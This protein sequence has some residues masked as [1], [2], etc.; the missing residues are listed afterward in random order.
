MSTENLMELVLEQ[1]NGPDASIAIPAKFTLLL[2]PYYNRLSDLN[3]E[4]G[5]EEGMS[6]L[7][8][9]VAGIATALSTLVANTPEQYRGDILKAIDDVS[10]RYIKMAIEL[11]NRT[12][13]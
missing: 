8:G 3:N 7:A 6:I 10:S 4:A 5:K 2:H 13:Q 9:L 11:K 12:V 1:S